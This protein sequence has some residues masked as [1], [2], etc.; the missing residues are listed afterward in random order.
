MSDESRASIEHM[1]GDAGVILPPEEFAAA[2]AVPSAE[3]YEAAYRR[4]IEDPDGFWGDAAREELEW[5]TPFSTVRSGGF[6]NLDYRWF[7]DGTLNVAANCLDR[8]LT[9]WRRNKAALIW[10]G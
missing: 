2:A 10:E 9:T 6:E 5:M 7:E 1:S 8:H 4:S 3:A